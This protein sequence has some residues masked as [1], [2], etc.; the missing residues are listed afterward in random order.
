[1]C[2]SDISQKCSSIYFKSPQ[3]PLADTSL[4]WNT[5]AF[6]LETVETISE[7]IFF[8]SH[9]VSKFISILY[10]WKNL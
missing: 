7:K 1:M 6:V 8:F 4:Q 2:I 5:E 3:A 9:C 10:F